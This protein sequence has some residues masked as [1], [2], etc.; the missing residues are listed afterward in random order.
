MNKK[1]TWLS[2]LV[3]SAIAALIVL[4][5]ISLEIDTYGSNTVLFMEFLSDGFFV[6][7][8]L[9]LGCSVLMFI[10]EAG[11]FYG[12]QYLGHVFLRMFSS[13]K[14]RFDSRKTYFEFCNE[15]KEKQNE[16]GKSSLK[17]VL[18]FVGLVCLA[19]SVVFLLVFYQIG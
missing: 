4:M 18:L 16:Q 19:I 3:A 10:A 14:D 12:I 17:W 9:Y 11:N 8:V 1:K 13:S 7:A 6:A 5:T 15:K 2:Y